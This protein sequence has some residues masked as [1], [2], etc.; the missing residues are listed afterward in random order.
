[1]ELLLTSHLN[2]IVF[3]LHTWKRSSSVWKKYII[4]QK[5]E[6]ITTQ[7]INKRGCYS[8]IV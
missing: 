6:G 5:S 3:K 7:E 4:T 1:M 2:L 8:V